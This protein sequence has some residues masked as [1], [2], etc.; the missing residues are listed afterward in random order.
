MLLPGAKLAP[1]PM[2]TLPA[3]E[4]EPPSS[5]P[6]TVTARLASEPSI[7]SRPPDTVV[8][9]VKVLAPLS[10]RLPV[11]SLVTLP[12]PLITP[13]KLP[14]PLTVRAPEPRAIVP[15][16][17]LTPAKACDWPARSSV[18]PLVSCSDEADANE[19]LAPKATVP[20]WMSSVPVNVLAALTVVVPLPV[21]TK[22]DA[23]PPASPI[24][25][26]IVAES[27]VVVV[28]SST[29]VPASVPEESVNEFTGTVRPAFTVSV[30]P[31]L[32]VRSTFAFRAASLSSTS[33]PPLTV[34]SP[35]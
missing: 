29:P 35:V 8:P 6:E 11:P 14:A 15:P 16:V 23:W 34:T 1:L 26:L 25:V 4:P 3:I 17:P 22:F 30:A 18:A 10:T 2:L 5:P 32:S 21:F 13:P 27:T 33:S 7:E 19:P 12:V 20:P 28:A 24:G 9:P 31:E